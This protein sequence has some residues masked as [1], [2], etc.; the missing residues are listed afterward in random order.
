MG[1]ASKGG[2]PVVVVCPVFLAG[3]TVGDSSGAVLGFGAV[4]GAGDDGA[5]GVE[6]EFGAETTVEFGVGDEVLPGGIGRGDVG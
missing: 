3:E 4:E 6:D 1:V 2:Q 5:G